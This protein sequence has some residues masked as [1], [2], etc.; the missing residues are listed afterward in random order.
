[1]ENKQLQKTINTTYFKY[2]SLPI[3]FIGISFV[4]PATESTIPNYTMGILLLYAIFFA[5]V[6]ELL[7]R[8]IFQ[9]IF[10]KM[11]LF[12]IEDKKILNVIWIVPVL[13]SSYLFMLSHEVIWF[14]VFILSFFL[15]IVYYYYNNILLNIYLHL[16]N[17]TF[18]V[19][20]LSLQW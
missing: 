1:M 7:F 17:N 11:L 19:L 6:E 3:L 13:S 10:W 16:L 4:L 18:F 9:N 14:S 8:W 12:C 5:I 2:I 15:W 20:L